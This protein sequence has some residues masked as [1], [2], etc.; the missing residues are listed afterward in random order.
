MERLRR[1]RERR[2]VRDITT[3]VKSFSPGE[4]DIRKVIIEGAD[5]PRY[6]FAPAERSREEV[7]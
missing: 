1:I 7:Q 2:A 3:I 6:S 4:E 5:S